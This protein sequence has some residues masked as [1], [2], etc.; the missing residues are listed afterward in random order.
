MTSHRGQ[1]WSSDTPY[2]LGRS[3]QV[4]RPIYLTE[5]LSPWALSR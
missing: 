4:W 3:P 1:S 2:A 5:R